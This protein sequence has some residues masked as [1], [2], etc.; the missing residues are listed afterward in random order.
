MS[1]V[2]RL[3]DRRR[4]AGSAHAALFERH[5]GDD[6]V[7]LD[8]E[9]T[10][11]DSRTD[12]VLTLAAVPVEGAV[13]RLSQALSLTVRGAT[14]FR[15]ES[16]RHHRLR[17]L[18]IAGGSELDAVLD[19]FL[20]RLGNR[21][22][23]GYAIAFDVALLDRLVEAR[24]GFR[25]P[26][27]VIEL[28]EVYRDAWQRRHPERAEP[29]LDYEALMAATGVPVLARHTA[30]GDAVTTAMAWVRLTHGPDPWRRT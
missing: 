23:L 2:R 4:M 16:M 26:N 10:G 1:F 9:T 28:R 30:L 14:D 15:I 20:E 6:C 21:P 7:A 12:S 8:L 17:P 18:D 22:I 3:L 24:H 5:R 11:L 27:R 25:L 29:A 19:A 13:V